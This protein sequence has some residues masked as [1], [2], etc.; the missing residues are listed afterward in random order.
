M[1][2]LFGQEK[3]NSN[4]HNSFLEEQDNPLIEINF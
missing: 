4:V 1:S 3:K 2:E